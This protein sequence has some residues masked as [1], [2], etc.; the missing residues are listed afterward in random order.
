MYVVHNEVV[1]LSGDAFPRTER[2]FLSSYGVQT[3]FT[4]IELDN[5]VGILPKKPS[6]LPGGKI[7]FKEILNRTHNSA[8][9][10]ISPLA[11]LRKV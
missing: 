11:L 1:V 7:A 10:R 8:C 3:N 9:F 2:A 4:F 6:W 5:L